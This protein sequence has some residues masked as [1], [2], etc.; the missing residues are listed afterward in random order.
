M[1]PNSLIP[2]TA[3]W[4]PGGPAG[5]ASACG[6]VTATGAESALG[7]LEGVLRSPFGGTGKIPTEAQF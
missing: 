5:V 2:E 3:K 6:G 7:G 4:V 1:L